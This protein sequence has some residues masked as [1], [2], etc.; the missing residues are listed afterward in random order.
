MEILDLIKSGDFSSIKAEFESNVSK[1]PFKVTYSDLEKQ[2]DP[3]K[4]DVFDTTKRPKKEVKKDTGSKDSQGNSV[5]QTV[6]EDVSRI[7]IPFQK[8]IV[9]RAVGFLLGNKVKLN[10]T[11][12]NDNETKIFESVKWIWQKNK[13]DYELKNVAEK[14]MSECEVAMLVYLVEAEAG[15]W[16][17]L[18][19]NIKS[20]FGTGGG[21]FTAKIKTLANSNGD[22]LYPHFNAYGDMDAFMRKY[23]VDVNGEKE[24]RYDVYTAGLILKYVQSGG[25]YTSTALVN[26]IG[27]IPVVYMRQDEADWYD[28]QSMI[29]RIE[30][31]IS[32]WADTDDYFGSPMLKSKGTVKGFASKGERGKVFQLEG[33][34]ADISAIS[35]DSAPESVK[36]EYLN[37]KELV[38]TMTQTPDISFEQVRTLGDISGIALK[39]MFLDAHMKARDKEGIFG[40]GIQRLLNILIATVGNAISTSLYQDSLNIEISPEFTP[41][42]PKNTKEDQEVIDA[43]VTSGTLSKET[44][45]ELSPLVSDPELE[46]ERLAKESAQSV[47]EPYM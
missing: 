29:E 2:Y 33:E 35:W 12:D 43:A 8:L 17:K 34:D 10:C 30:T 9:N 25:T 40:L 38:Y 11:S 45:V 1:R 36:T 20:L 24:E 44:A 41:F 5:Y 14:L 27:K 16:A 42:L 31:L 46:K 13:L 15:F 39:M 26:A 7:A 6:L 32:N 37:L 18:M 19:L 3:S 22:T 23:T 28:V 21:K 4:H 47:S